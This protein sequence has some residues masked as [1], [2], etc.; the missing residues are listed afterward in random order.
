MQKQC[1]R[2][3]CVLCVCISRSDERLFGKPT[4][5]K[6]KKPDCVLSLERISIFCVVEWHEPKAFRS[7]QII[8]LWFFDLLFFYPQNCILRRAR[9]RAH[10][11]KEMR[12][13]VCSEENPWQIVVFLLLPWMCCV[14]YQ[15]SLINDRYLY[16][17]PQVEI[18]KEVNSR[19]V[20]ADGSHDINHTKQ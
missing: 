20:V 13:F 6:Q 7:V 1:G 16:L 11:L 12:V 8:S 15:Q 18:T 5:R 2:A 9:P 17:F 10:C 3:F 4:K 19:E 14:V